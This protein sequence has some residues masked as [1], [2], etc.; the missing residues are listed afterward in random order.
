[1]ERNLNSIDYDN[2]GVKPKL[3]L[4][5]PDPRNDNDSRFVDYSVLSKKKT[6]FEMMME[7]IEKNHR[8]PVYYKKEYWFDK[9][10]ESVS[11]EA[12]SQSNYSK[13]RLVS[14]VPSQ[15]E[16]RVIKSHAS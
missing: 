5:I 15:V 8:L 2:S 9:P 4:S 14:R 13:E 3:L 12:E 7:D 11:P 1:M 10:K 16:M 6:D